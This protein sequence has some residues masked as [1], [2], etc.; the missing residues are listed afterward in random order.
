MVT[1]DSS[2]LPITATPVRKWRRATRPAASAN[3]SARAMKPGRHAFVARGPRSPIVSVP[4]FGAARA[5]LP[6]IAA[7]GDHRAS[8]ASLV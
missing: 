2:A 8:G 1:G 6:R 4:P 7:R 5:A 3:R